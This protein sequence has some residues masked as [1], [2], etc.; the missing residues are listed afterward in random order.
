MRG[1]VWRG[2]KDLLVRDGQGLVGGHGI[3]W[4]VKVHRKEQRWQSKGVSGWSGRG[5]HLAERPRVRTGLSYMDKQDRQR[6]LGRPCSLKRAKGRSFTQ[7]RWSSC[8]S[9][10]RVFFKDQLVCSIFPED[11][12][13]YGIWKYQ[14]ILRALDRVWEIWEVNSG[15]LSEWMEVGSPKHRIIS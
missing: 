11:W 14:R 13:W 7:Q 1:L 5:K 10:T 8:D 3:Q 4:S 9:L 15:L 2:E 6:F 12:G